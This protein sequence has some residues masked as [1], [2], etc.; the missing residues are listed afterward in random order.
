[1]RAEDRTLTEEEIAAIQTRLLA[2]LRER[3]QIDLRA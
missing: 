1:M 3:F 2:H